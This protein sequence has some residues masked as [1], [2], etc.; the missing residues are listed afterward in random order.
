M[1][2]PAFAPKAIER[3]APQT[4]AICRELIDRL[5]DKTHCDGDVD[6]AQEVPV[7]VIASMFGV[8]ERDGERFRRW[9]HEF[10]ESGVTDMVAFRRATDEVKEYVLSEM[11]KRRITPGDDLITYLL[12]ARIDGQPLSDDDAVGTLRL[13]LFA[14]IDTTWCMIGSCLWHLATHP[15][16]R[17]RLV[18][19]PGL[20][21]T[22]IEE[23]L[24]AYAPATLGREVVKETQIGGCAF[25]KTKWCCYPFRPR[26]ATPRFS[27]SLIVSSSTAPPIPM[28]RS[29]WVFTDA[30][31]PTWRAW[32]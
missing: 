21:R 18:A 17:K 2:L 15:D 24:R 6:Y 32:R 25:K 12:N 13:L 16:D 19:E 1:L 30:S 5:R 11:A 29:G 28:S 20:V 10:L 3:Y 9:V 26:I 22:A 7:R 31:V 23:F 4:R 27:P 8:S 14:G